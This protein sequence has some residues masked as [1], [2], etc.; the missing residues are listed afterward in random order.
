MKEG[1]FCHMCV[2]VPYVFEYRCH[3]V[4][5]CVCVCVCHSDVWTFNW[6][7][8]PLLAV[9]EEDFIAIMTGDT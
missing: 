9:S 5:V 7:F 8:N 1:V 4:C 6:F 2:C 3:C